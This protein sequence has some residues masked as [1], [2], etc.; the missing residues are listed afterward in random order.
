M[1]ANSRYRSRGFSCGANSK[2][3]FF[4]LC[5]ISFLFLFMI[6]FP[7][8]HGAV[9]CVLIVVLY[10]YN[11]YNVRTYSFHFRHPYL[12][13]FTFYYLFGFTEIKYRS[14]LVR[15]QCVF[16]LQVLS[17]ESMKENKL[18]QHLNTFHPH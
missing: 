12:L 14:G 1:S 18:K 17:N 3:T 7:E 5:R 6:Y 11:M 9:W 16:C 8:R 15:P 4:E 2:S 13:F 10:K